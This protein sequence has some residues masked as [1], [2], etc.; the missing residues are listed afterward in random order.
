MR[1]VANSRV[2]CA[3]VIESELA[4]TNAPTKS[5]TPGERKQERLEEADEAVRV[6]RVARRLG[7]P[8]LHL[9]PH[10]EDR[11]NLRDE[12]VGR[13]AALR[14]DA[15]LVEL[16]RLVEEALGGREIEARERRAADGGDRAEP[17]EARDAKPLD[18]TLRLHAE[19]LTDLDVLLARRRLVDH[20][21]TG[22]RPAAGDEGEGVEPGLRRIDA[23]PEVRRASEDDRL[24]VLADQLRL[25]AHAANRGPHVRQRLHLRQQRLVEG[26]GGG[27]PTAREIECRLAADHRVR[28]LVALREDRVEGIRDRVREDVGAAHHRDAEDDR[29]CRE[30]GTELVAEKALE[31]KRRHENETSAVALTTVRALAHLAVSPEPSQSGMSCLITTAVP[32]PFRIKPPGE[33]RI[34][35][36]KTA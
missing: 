11:A 17:D 33:G 12:L 13:D 6:L 28:S 23:E 36:T 25:A 26:R 32:C 18:G 3:I 30:S 21:L 2:R 24:P 14:T 35:A 20:D 22:L 34:G 10:G 15:D 4:M 29:N 1:R 31:R 16:P 7:V 27:S 9:D 8:T 5:A 19:L